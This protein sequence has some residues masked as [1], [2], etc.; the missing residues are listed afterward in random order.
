MNKVLRL[1]LF[2]F[3]TCS[4]A[5]VGVNTKLPLHPLHID[6][7][8]NNPTSAIPSEN[9]AKDDFVVTKEGNVGIG[10][11]DPKAKLEVIGNVKIIDGNQA[12]DKVL[13][14]DETGVGKLMSLPETSPAVV[15][16]FSGANV[17]N[18]ST[19]ANSYSFANAS[20]TLKK[21]KWIVTW[22]LTMDQ[23]GT[24][25]LWLESCLSTLQTSRA[26]VG[27]NFVGNPLNKPSIGANLQGNPDSSSGNYDMLVG[28][29]V[30]EVTSDT[31]LQVFILLK[32]DGNWS[33]SPT[34]WENYFYALPIK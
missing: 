31:P 1:M 28:S 33:F 2:I 5:Q 23:R 3:S 7:K 29:S 11:I 4:M 25:D 18:S 27:F 30:I 15:G 26:E 12:G 20:I 13:T 34:S 17:T 10:T 32:R 14:S 16:S 19:I 21:G 8:K 22:G 9:E 6:A 24:N